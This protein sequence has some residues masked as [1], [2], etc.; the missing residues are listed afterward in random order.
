MAKWGEGR[1]MST[2]M[3]DSSSQCLSE[4]ECESS[5][6]NAPLENLRPIRDELAVRG[7]VI[8]CFPFTYR[9]RRYFTLVQRYMPPEETPQYQLVKLTFI[10]GR[11]T[12][13][14]LTAAANT[15][16]IAAG[17]RELREYFGIEYGPNLGEILTQFCEQLGKF[18]PSRLPTALSPEEKTVVLS[19]LGRSSSE[20]PNKVHCFDVRRN[21]TRSNGTLNQRSP[22][23]SQ[24]TEMLRPTLYEALKADENLS[25][26]Y[27]EHPEDERSDTEILESFNCRR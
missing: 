25:F 23:N 7:W 14:T 8:A 26:Y 21:G 5:N 20:D 13:R 24:K 1:T 2:R 12:S 11:D 22:F 3:V 15:Q 27:S 6:M 19:Q 10:D 18:I 4:G 16:R 17:A 9:Q